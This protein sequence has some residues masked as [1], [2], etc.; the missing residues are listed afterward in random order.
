MTWTVRNSRAGGPFTSIYSLAI[1]PR[2]H[3]YD[4]AGNLEGGEGGRGRDARFLGW[5]F[6]A[7]STMY[8]HCSGV[9]VRLTGVWATEH[10]VEQGSSVRA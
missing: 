2:Y 6:I 1:C 3:V 4:I 8:M 10:G 9:S 7:K 5:R